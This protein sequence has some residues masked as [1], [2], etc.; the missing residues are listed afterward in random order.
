MI[1]N[2]W[3]LN[4]YANL[5]S[6]RHYKVAQ[7]LIKRGYNVKIFAASTIHNSN[8]NRITD[9]QKYI[10]E[11]K[12]GIQCIYIKAINYVGNGKARIKNMIDY[13]M[14]LMSISKK[15]DFDK[16]DIILASSV[17]PL[18]WISG[19]SLSKRYN[20][21]FIAETRDLWPE[22]LVAMEQIRKN[23]IPA[24][25]LY[26]LEKFIY[27]KSDKLIFT[28]PGGKDYVKEMGLDNSKVRYVN[29]GIDIEEFKYNEKQNRHRDIDLDEIGT[30]KVLYTGSMGQANAL[31]YLIK[32]AKIIEDKGI[33][34]IKIILFGD[35]YQ[36][37]QLEKCVKDNNLKNVVFKQKVEKKYI[38]TILS[39]SNLNIFTGKH[40][41]L[42]KYGL[43]PNKMFDYFASGKPTLSNIEC[44]YDMLQ[45]YNCGI[46]VKG[47]SAEA[48]AE[49]I[50]KFYSMSKE[51][52]NLYCQNALIAAQDFDFK[53]LTDK[54]ESII[55]ELSQQN[56]GEIVNANSIN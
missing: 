51:E 29:N 38:P 11:D 23:S 55:L 56:K 52:Y 16:P 17:H 9:S 49:G 46:T 25:I 27:K 6:G 20:A 22:T 50:L 37:E 31:D 5:E 7:N 33:K 39:K 43:S 42:Y 14:R 13:A 48:L 35:G 53:V 36:R 15:F 41:Y 54:L 45:E 34:D 18:T 12:D 30:F 19:Y 21:K 40:I 44:G 2:I 10:V 32:S 28:F 47:G 24:K 1:K 26:K 4:H 3:I 8:V